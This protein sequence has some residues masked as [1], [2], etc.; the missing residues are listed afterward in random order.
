MGKSKSHTDL[1]VVG[2]TRQKCLAHGCILHRNIDLGQ[3]VYVENL[4][5]TNTISL[6]TSPCT[7]RPAM[8]HLLSLA[9]E[10]GS[11]SSDSAERLA[12]AP[13]AFV[14]KLLA[15]QG[16]YLQSMGVIAA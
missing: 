15:P 2:I 12:S 3:L 10:M 11:F 6:P 14:S 16:V 7:T 13:S 8:G 1:I 5:G 4:C 9:F